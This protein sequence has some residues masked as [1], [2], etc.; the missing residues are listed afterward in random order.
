MDIGK[1][2]DS[3]LEVPIFLG[4]EARRAE[5]FRLLGNYDR[6]HEEL[7]PIHKMLTAMKN[8][9]KYLEEQKKKDGVNCAAREKKITE[10]REMIDYIEQGDTYRDLTVRHNQAFAELQDWCEKGRAAEERDN[11]TPV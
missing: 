2:I 3:L 8:E 7:N 9:N 10:N 4:D 11:G 6:F 1:V 5:Y